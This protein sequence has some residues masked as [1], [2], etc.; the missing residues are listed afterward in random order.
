MTDLDFHRVNDMVK[1]GVYAGSANMH[2]LIQAGWVV[3]TIIKDV[4]SYS[5][6][7]K[8]FTL[9]EQDWK[10]RQ[11]LERRAGSYYSPRQPKAYTH[12]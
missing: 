11:A 5:W 6:T 1:H 4:T 2:Q 12:G 10:T 8:F 7:K 9:A 3:K